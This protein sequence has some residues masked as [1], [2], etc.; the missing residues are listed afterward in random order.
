MVK[1]IATTYALIGNG[2]ENAMTSEVLMVVKRG[3]EYSLEVMRPWSRQTADRIAFAVTMDSIRSLAEGATVAEG[4]TAIDKLT[5]TIV[6]EVG[7]SG[8]WAGYCFESKMVS[9]IP[10][11]SDEDIGAGQF[12]VKNVQSVAFRLVNSVG[13]AVRAYLSEGSLPA[14]L[15]DGNE[16][17]ALK[18]ENGV[19]LTPQCDTKVVMAG[20]NNRDGRVELAQ[21]EPWPFMTILMESDIAVE[22]EGQGQ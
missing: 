1:A 20:A 17:L 9:A 10:L 21:D 8:A 12:D 19:V 11:I 13:G 7:E 6:E 4:M 16:A 2:G 22:V 18:V 15:V 14:R 5:G 3:D